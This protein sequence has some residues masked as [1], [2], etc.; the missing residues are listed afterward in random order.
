ML[1]FL[2][3]EDRSVYKQSGASD[4]ML[5]FVVQRRSINLQTGA[6]DPMQSGASDSMLCFLYKEDRSDCKPV[7]QIRCCAFC[8]KKI[9][10]FKNNPVQQIRCCAFCTKKIDRFPCSEQKL[11]NFRTPYLTKQL[12]IRE[13]SNLG[14]YIHRIENDLKK[15]Y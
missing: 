15:L 12:S 7:H 2:Y 9:D 4:S 11:R 8:T 10:R 1:C 6:S 14:H 5:C 3:K 13:Y